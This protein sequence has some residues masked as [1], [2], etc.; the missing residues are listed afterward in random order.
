VRDRLLEP[1]SSSRFAAAASTC[2]TRTRRT[3]NRQLAGGRKD[4]D[5]QDALHD[6]SA[7]ARGVL[8]P[9]D[10]SFFA[11]CSG[12]IGG[13]VFAIADAVTTGAPKRKASKEERENYL[14]ALRDHRVK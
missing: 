1:S 7:L 10:S 6:T 9:L 2:S 12:G 11:A 3:C 8:L 5:S 13:V 14:R 4:S